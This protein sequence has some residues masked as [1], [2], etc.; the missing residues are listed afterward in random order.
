MQNGSK[1]SMRR[2]VQGKARKTL[3]DVKKTVSGAAKKTTKEAK[4]V[5]QNARQTVR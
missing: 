1:V 4:K 5:P 2:T 3:Q